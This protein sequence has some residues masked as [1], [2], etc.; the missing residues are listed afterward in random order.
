[1]KYRLKIAEN[2]LNIFLHAWLITYKLSCTEAVKIIA[3]ILK[4]FTIKG[5]EEV[6]DD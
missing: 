6:K 1:M 3:S 5:W 2:D 4:D